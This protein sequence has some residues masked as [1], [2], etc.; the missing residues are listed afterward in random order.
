MRKTLLNFVIVTSIPKYVD[1]QECEEIARAMMARIVRRQLGNVDIKKHP[2][3]PYAIVY[4]CPQHMAEA[5]QQ[6]IDLHF[7]NNRQEINK[8]WRRFDRKK[9]SATV[10]PL[11]GPLALSASS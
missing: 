9:K 10:I 3:I 6:L 7:E 11:P 8:G 4:R 2:S 5:L 1:E